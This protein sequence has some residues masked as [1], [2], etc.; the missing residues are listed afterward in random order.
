MWQAL[1]Q[2]QKNG[3]TS[4]TLQATDVGERLYRAL[5]FRHLCL[6]QLW[7]LRR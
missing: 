1:E 3:C 7:E 5:G 6:M 4:T 2:A